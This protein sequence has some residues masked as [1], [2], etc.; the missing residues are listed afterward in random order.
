MASKRAIIDPIRMCT[1]S[2]IHRLS[3]KHTK[4]YLPQQ[5]FII[6]YYVWWPQFSILYLDSY[7][8]NSHFFYGL[9]IGANFVF[10]KG[11]PEAVGERQSAWN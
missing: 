5:D 6:S 3:S 10:S 11:N 8:A 1:L 4:R 9:Q 2:V 7:L